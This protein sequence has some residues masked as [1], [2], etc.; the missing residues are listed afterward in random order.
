MNCYHCGEPLTSDDY[1]LDK[2]ITTS[3][4]SASAH[5]ECIVNTMSLNDAHYIEPSDRQD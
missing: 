4:G 1:K 2:V 5:W 3:D